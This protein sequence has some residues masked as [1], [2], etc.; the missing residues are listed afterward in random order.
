MTIGATKSRWTRSEARP[1]LAGHGRPLDH[2][3][4]S[5]IGATAW[6]GNDLSHVLCFLSARESLKDKPPRLNSVGACSARNKLHAIIY[7]SIWLFG[8][9]I[10]PPIKLQA[11]SRETGGSDRIMVCRACSLSSKAAYSLQ[12]DETFRFYQRLRKLEM[13]VFRLPVYLQRMYK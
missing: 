3:E 11:T 6:L 10:N 1:T 7:Y 12:M 8:Q 5:M 9:P 13:R 2:S 4:E